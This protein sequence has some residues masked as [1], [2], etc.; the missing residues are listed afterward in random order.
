MNKLLTLLILFS[1]FTCYK[2]IGQNCT[3]PEQLRNEIEQVAIKIDV[4]E[5]DFYHVNNLLFEYEFENSLST[6]INCDC[7]RQNIMTLFNSNDEEKWV[8]AYR[9][10]GVAK[11]STFNDK[12]IEKIKSDESSLLKTWNC[13]ALMANKSSKASDELFK[14]FSS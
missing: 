5:D 1:L 7:Y 13:T 8:I 10:I 14:L 12:L 2:L 3:I 6:L 4:N 9:L 11:D